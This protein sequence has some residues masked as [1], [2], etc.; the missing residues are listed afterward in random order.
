M[1]IGNNDEYEFM[2]SRLT[3]QR[4]ALS[5]RRRYFLQ[6]INEQ[7]YRCYLQNISVMSKAMVQEHGPDICIDYNPFEP[8]RLRD[9]PV[10]VEGLSELAIR[11][12]GCSKALE[13]VERLKREIIE[14]E[15]MISAL[16]QQAAAVALGRQK[17]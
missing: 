4:E 17:E 7:L 11:I 15:A 16:N 8:L 3:Y 6:E 2:Q 5:L 1:A 12:G 10:R 9:I 14:S 13:L